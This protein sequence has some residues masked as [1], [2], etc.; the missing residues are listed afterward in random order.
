MEIQVLQTED[1]LLSFAK[2]VLSH[3]EGALEEQ[4]CICAL[5][6]NL[7]AGKTTFVQKIATHLGVQET[8]TSPTFII[9][10]TYPTQ[11]DIITTLVHIDAYRLED[12][13]ELEALGFKDLV[14]S[15][16][17]LICVEW[18]ER[19][20]SLFARNTFWLDFSI[21]ADESRLVTVRSPE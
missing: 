20:S 18:A 10:K 1:D 12:A 2:T 11:S 9:Q 14:Q 5:S 4:A 19:V 17:T 3:V 13:S 21:Q 7:G 15:P 6:G 8:V 16:H